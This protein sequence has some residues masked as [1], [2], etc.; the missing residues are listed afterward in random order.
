MAKIT[1]L[2]H[3]CFTIEDGIRIII[4]PWIN[5]N[6]A[7]PVKLKDVPKVDHILITH[8]HR[9]HLGD[10]FELAKRDHA[11]IIGIYELADYARKQGVKQT[12]GANIGSWFKVDN[13]KYLLTPALHTSNIGSPVGFM[14]ELPN[15]LVIYHAGDTGLFAELLF[16][17]E[18]HKIDV[19]LL[20]IGG[21]YTMGPIEATKAVQI[22]GPRIVIP[23]H[24]NTFPLIKQD[25]YEFKKLISQI[26]PDVEVKIMKPGETVEIK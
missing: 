11:K 26:R 25:P 16:I 18:L 21:Y 9:D 19:A 20:P 5:G 2:G 12:I 8:D 4:D 15:G 24:Y 1:W 3:A 13:V 22:L 6:P 7:C 23:M 14:I 10:A 17:R